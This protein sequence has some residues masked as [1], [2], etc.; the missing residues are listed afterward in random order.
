MEI[1]LKLTILLLLPAAF[2]LLLAACGDNQ[3]TDT[4]TPEAKVAAKA[5]AQPTPTKEPPKSEP[6]KPPASEPIP[7]EARPTALA[8]VAEVASAT[9]PVPTPSATPTPTQVPPTAT[10]PIPTPTQMPPTYTLTPTPTPVVGKYSDRMGFEPV[11]VITPNPTPTVG[12]P[13]PLLEAFEATA[14]IV[15]Q[16]GETVRD[17]RYQLINNS[18]QKAEVLN[19]EVRRPNG[20]VIFS[21]IASAS[22]ASIG[23][24][25]K[26]GTAI[27]FPKSRRSPVLQEEIMASHGVWTIRTQTGETIV[28]TFTK[29]NPKS[30]VY[31]STP[32]PLPTATPTELPP[33]AT[34]TSVP[35]LRFVP[36]QGIRMDFA[37]L[38]KVTV[39]D[40]GLFYL[41]YQDKSGKRLKNPIAV[42]SDGLS[43]AE[44][45]TSDGSSRHPYA[46]E[47]P[48]GTWRRYILSENNVIKSESS[49]DGVMFTQD[50]GLRYSPSEEDRGT[51]GTY[52][53]FVD[54]EG[55]VVLLYVGDMKGLN[56]VRRAYSP[57]GDNGWTFSYERGNVLGDDRAGGGSRTFVDIKSVGLP[58]GRRRLF[59]MRG[60]TQILSFISD[61]DLGAFSLEP[62]VR[63]SKEDFIKLSVISLHDPMIIR[64]PDDR[65]RMYLHLHVKGQESGEKTVIVSATTPSP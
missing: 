2:I 47:L 50:E 40:D 34:P 11:P 39:G 35:S 42:S 38:A 64:L 31:T 19:G 9:T 21:L 10:A 15:F 52:D 37:A 49:V 33:T 30:C 12:K 14:H 5:I 18:Q 7:T 17:I 24:N 36:D 62:G 16:E 22:K 41:F 27:S 13:I 63:L 56:N 23:P 29:T 53:I 25:G 46:V 59:A 20:T 45:R 32:T 58:D 61:A 43:F 6:A 26:L 3:T 65:Y 48:D 60:G 1:N 51:L 55:G 8:K 44:G 54:K 28:C 4:P 57:P